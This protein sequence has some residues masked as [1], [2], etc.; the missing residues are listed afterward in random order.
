MPPGPGRRVGFWGFGGRSEAPKRRIQLREEFFVAHGPIRLRHV[1]NRWR[2]THMDTAE[3][4][5]VSLHAP[6]ADGDGL[7]RTFTRQEGRAD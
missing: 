3:D 6:S 5:F 2:T 7:G 4:G 1:A